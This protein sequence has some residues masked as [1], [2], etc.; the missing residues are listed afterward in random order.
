MKLIINANDMF[1]IKIKENGKEIL[2]KK[3]YDL[4]RTLTKKTKLLVH[5][6]RLWTFLANICI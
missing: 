6:G 4:F 3:D 1:T 5:F 2:R